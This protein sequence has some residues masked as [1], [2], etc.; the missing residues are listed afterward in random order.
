MPRFR[1]FCISIFAIVLAGCGIR[2]PDRAPSLGVAY[3][4]PVTLNLHQEIDPKSP[5]VAIVHHGD[6]LEIIG[7]RR[8]SWYRVR[9][10]KGIEGWTSNRELLDNAQMQRLRALAAETAGMPSQGAGTTFGT[11]NVHSEPNRQS[12]SFVQLGEHEKFD[13]VA[14]RVAAR[15]ALPRRELIPEVPKAPKKSAKENEKG[16]KKAVAILVPPPPASPSPP[17]DWAA[18]GSHQP[19]SNTAASA[20]ESAPVPTD[21]WT[22]IRTSSGQSGWVLTS[23]IYLQIPDEVAQYAEGHRIT[24]YFSIGKTA[25][26]GQQKDIW[27]WTTSEQLGEDHDFDSFR[28][29]TWSTR[30]HRYETAYIQRRERGFFPVIAKAGEFSLCLE[31]PAGLV[32]KQF[33]LT[34]NSVRPAGEKPCQKTADEEAATA[35][36]ACWRGPDARRAEGFTGP[37]QVS[38]Q[39]TVPSEA[40]SLSRRTSGQSQPAESVCSKISILNIRRKVPVNRKL[41]FVLPLVAGLLGGVLTRY[42][43]PPAAFAQAPAPSPKEI[44]AQSFTLVDAGNRTAG[45]FSVEPEPAQEAAR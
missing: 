19:D 23:A 16:K 35:E 18:L 9:T 37:D 29:F 32:R 40:V 26:G 44:R 24:S 31:K 14:H 6:K 8:R 30:R 11:V 45:T 41:N 4:G 2:Q 25:D 5:T 20:P 3:A 33:V 22:L 34:G 28:V 43:A 15:T 10:V 7:Q 36:S 12:T 38:R 42:I 13:V 39:R 27:L 17:P 1:I 21:D